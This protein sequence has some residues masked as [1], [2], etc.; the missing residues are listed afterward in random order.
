MP[1]VPGTHGTPFVLPHG[2]NVP[3]FSSKHPTYRPTTKTPLPTAR[4]TTV[5]WTRLAGKHC[6]AHRLPASNPVRYAN[7]AIAKSECMDDPNCGGV[8]KPLGEQAFFLCDVRPTETSHEGGQ[9]W[10]RPPGWATSV[11]T[12]E[13]LVEGFTMWC[14][15]WCCCPT[16]WHGELCDDVDECTST[17]CLNG[18]ACAESSS[19]YLV[20]NY[21]RKYRCACL[22][23]FHGHN[24][25]QERAAGVGK[26]ALRLGAK[27]ASGSTTTLQAYTEFQ[28]ALQFTGVTIQSKNTDFERMCADIYESHENGGVCG[29]QFVLYDKTGQA[30]A[31][32][33][34]NCTVDGADRSELFA[35]MSLCASPCM[36]DR[37]ALGCYQR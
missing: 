2:M 17:P 25:D 8:Y 29:Q 5:E 37:S 26:C 13:R 22:A 10:R 15:N 30:I 18:G 27:S 23:G 20:N 35:V 7:H 19:T 28:M 24:C 33:V 1:T 9:V 3:G 6:F 16:G 32:P 11:S 36:R 12:G 31:T 21:F 14:S 4:P 34:V